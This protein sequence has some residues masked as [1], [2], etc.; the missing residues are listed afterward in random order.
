MESFDIAIVADLGR[1]GDN[2]LRIGQEIWA[3]SAS[4]YRLGLVH[5]GARGANV[6]M[7]PEVLRQIR[8]GR[9]EI[10]SPSSSVRAKLLICYPRF[11]RLPGLANALAVDRSLLVFDDLPDFDPMEVH[12]EMVSLFG[13]VT[14]TP[15]NPW[16][17]DHLTSDYPAL[18]VEPFNWSASGPLTAASSVERPTPPLRIGVIATEGQQ[19]VLP[20]LS[21]ST[22]GSLNIIHVECGD[23]APGSDDAL[24]PPALRLRE[25]AIER[26]V[27]RIDAIVYCPPADQLGHPDATIATALAWGKPVILAQHLKPHYRTGPIYCD[28]DRLGA[29]VEKL[30]RIVRDPRRAPRRIAGRSAW[31]SYQEKVRTLLGRPSRPMREPDGRTPEEVK[32]ALFVSTEGGTES[33]MRLLAIARRAENKCRP[34]FVTTHGTFHSIEA[35]GYVA[36]HIAPQQHTTAPLSD[37][38]AWFRVEFDHLIDVHRARFVIIGDSAPCQAVL[39]SVG[40]RGDCMFAWATTELTTK[41]VG[42][43]DW[44][45][46]DRVLHIDD[47]GR[48]AESSARHV[49]DKRLTCVHPITLFDE[50][51]LLTRENAAQVLGLDHGKPT[52]L[53][54][55]AIDSMEVSHLTHLIKRMDELRDLQVVALDDGSELSN[56]VWPPGVVIVKGVPIAQYLNAFDLAVASPGYCAFHESIAHSLPTI[57]VTGGSHDQNSQ[58]DRVQSAETAGAAIELPGANLA[59]LPM[60][61]RTLLARQANDFMRAN[62]RRFYRGNGACDAANALLRPVA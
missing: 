54:R 36:E 19:F 45:H 33:L 2:G 26:V 17:R 13:I 30:S 58:R 27:D 60:M 47:L 38:L 31:R 49:T 55:P 16:L 35:F 51:E 23:Q 53:L 22:N 40:P 5:A 28:P 57:F 37:W 15:T 46:F 34:I 32:T 18:P 29:A 25:F 41:R 7:H 56:L 9:A 50:D 3:N 59:S 24:D 62:C 20:E 39:D 61:V 52:I 21:P 43:L 8:Q 42:M 6:R 4:G 44:P 10:I 11:V 1:A 14:W 12:R 48:L